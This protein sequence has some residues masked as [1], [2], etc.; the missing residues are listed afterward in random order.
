VHI[1]YVNTPTNFTADNITLDRLKD[2]AKKSGFRNYT[3]NVFNYPFAEAGI[4]HFTK[5][6]KGDLIAMGTH[7]RT[8]ISH[9]LNG[10][11][12]EDMVNHADGPIWTFASRG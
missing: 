7:G 3:L 2:F 5:R 8:G 1:V 6:M 11:L 12:A 10:S 4:I 9:F